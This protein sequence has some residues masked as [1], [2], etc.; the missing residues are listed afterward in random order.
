MAFG[1]REAKET[2][3]GTDRQGY[4]EDTRRSVT[5]A[6]GRLVLAGAT[7]TQHL[8]LVFPLLVEAIAH[9]VAPNIRQPADHHSQTMEAAREVT[10]ELAAR[11]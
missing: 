1:H 6:T 3:D 10:A 5:P 8:V 11:P 2:I 7:T 9:G 4:M